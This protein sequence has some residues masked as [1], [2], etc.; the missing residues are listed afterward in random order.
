MTVKILLA[1][2]HPLFR[3]GMHYLLRQLDGVTVLLEAGDIVTALALLREHADLDLILLD[4]NMPGMEGFSGYEALEREV[5]EIPIVIVSASESPLDIQHALEA[6]AAGYI[7][8][9]F[10]TETMVNALQLV[11]EGRTYRPPL[12]DPELALLNR[13]SGRQATVLRL[14]CDGLDNKRIAERLFISENTV[15]H[16]VTTIFKILG[17]NSRTQAVLKARELLS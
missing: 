17:V 16:H 1:D 4:L 12:N 13:L 3:D 7:P 11:L 14:I 15:K 8:K 9:S 10:T 2:D 6:G 5:P